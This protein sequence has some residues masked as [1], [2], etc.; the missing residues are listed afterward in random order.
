MGR[1]RD[2]IDIHVNIPIEINNKLNVI[3]EGKAAGEKTFHITTALRKFLQDWEK[4]NGKI[5]R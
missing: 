1:K 2:L 5:G 4:R 3:S